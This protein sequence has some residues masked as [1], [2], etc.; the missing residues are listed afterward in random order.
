MPAPD[1]GDVFL[2][3]E[4]HPFWR[5]ARGLFFLFG[6][7]AVTTRRRLDVP[8]DVG[9]RPRAEEAATTKS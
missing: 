5:A 7:I 9:A 6:C 4:G 1:D 2:D 8:A 3:F